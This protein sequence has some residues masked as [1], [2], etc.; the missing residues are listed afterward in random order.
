M[1]VVC[2]YYVCSVYIR[3]DGYLLQKRY[4]AICQVFST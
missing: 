2:V 1:Y 3:I 4:N